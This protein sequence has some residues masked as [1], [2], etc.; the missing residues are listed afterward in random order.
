[1]LLY[2]SCFVVLSSRPT[3]PPRALPPF[4]TRRSSDLQTLQYRP[5]AAARGKQRPLVNRD[6]QRMFEPI[7]ITE[8]FLLKN[9]LR[10]VLFRK[11]R[12]EEHTSELQSRVD[13]VC[14]LLLEKKKKLRISTRA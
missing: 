1:L 11:P 2:R 6:I 12:S 8:Q 13:L 9:N 7:R 10:E 5:Y 14:R 3:A 4:P